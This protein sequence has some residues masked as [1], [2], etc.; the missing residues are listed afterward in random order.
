M[1]SSSWLSQET[2][3]EGLRNLQAALQRG[4]LPFVILVEDDDM[5][6]SRFRTALR[7][8]GVSVEFMR[9]N[10]AQHALDFFHGK[11]DFA[12][13]EAFPL[14]NLTVLDWNLPSSSGLEVLEQIRAHPGLEQLTVI[15]LT[16]SND[17]GQIEKAR[18]L[19]INDWINKPESLRRSRNDRATTQAILAGGTRK[20]EL[21]E[22]KVEA[23]FR[24]LLHA[25][26]EL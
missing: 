7:R 22:Q 20:K 10:N 9:F 6:A 11:G 12:D 15:A 18:F 2:I 19:K 25:F 4:R 21:S 8:A 24:A 26:L 13:R 5:D 14:P 3:E 16:A 1:K 17:V 23:V